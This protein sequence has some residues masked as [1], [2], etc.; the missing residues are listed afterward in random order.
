MAIPD[1]QSLML[2]VLE[3][4]SIAE[5]RIGAVVD[6]LAKQLDLSPEER[7]ALLPSGGHARGASANC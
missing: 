7:A 3:A 2:P 6:H 1:Y 4:S 5:V